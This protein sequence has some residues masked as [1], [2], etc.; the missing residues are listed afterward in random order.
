[1]VSGVNLLQVLMLAAKLLPEKSQSLLK[2]RR[3]NIEPIQISLKFGTTRVKEL[4]LWHMSLKQQEK[5]MGPHRSCQKV[6]LSKA[7]TYT[8]TDT[9]GAHTHP[10]LDFLATHSIF[11]P[12]CPR[13]TSLL[14]QK[15]RGASD[16]G[17]FTTRVF[18]L[19][20]KSEFQLHWCDRFTRTP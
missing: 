1:M 20:R 18:G 17:V 7:S 15:G 5:R 8:P 19:F 6:E 11:L 9:S 4:F 3:L 16:L 12:E 13:Y 2:P 10:P 14:K